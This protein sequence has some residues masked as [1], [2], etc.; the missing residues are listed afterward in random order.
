[1][2]H[3]SA[4]FEFFSVRVLDVSVLFEVYRPP[5]RHAGA[6]FTETK[7]IPYLPSSLTT[8]SQHSPF[9]PPSLPPTPITPAA[10]FT[11]PTSKLKNR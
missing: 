11:S 10:P 1:M 5:S 4:W 2:R 7:V 9:S 6:L 8:R 3:L